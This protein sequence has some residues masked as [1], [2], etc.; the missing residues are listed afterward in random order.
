VVQAARLAMQN[1]ERC[2]ACD[3]ISIAFARPGRRVPRAPVDSRWYGPARSTRRVLI[4]SASVATAIGSGLFYSGQGAANAV[5][6][7]LV[8][9]VIAVFILLRVAE[10]PDDAR[11]SRRLTR[12]ER[13]LRAAGGELL[14]AAGLGVMLGFAHAWI[15][16]AAYVV[17]V[18]A[19]VT[20]SMHRR[21]SAPPAREGESSIRSKPRTSTKNTIARS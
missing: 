13:R 6:W 21:A 5:A 15:P 18:L 8:T 9:F 3:P 17:A 10:A 1:W 4:V 7:V 12:R 11:R 14:S 19:F 2:F 20:W 16:L